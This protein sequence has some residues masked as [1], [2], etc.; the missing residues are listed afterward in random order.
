MILCYH[1]DICFSDPVFPNLSGAE[2][3]EMW[4]MLCS[5][6][7]NFEVTFAD[8]EADERT[9]KAHWEACYDFSATGRRVHN[10]IDAEFEFQDG[11]IIKHK[12][13]F[14][15]WKWSS[16]ALGPVEFILGWTPLLRKKVQRQA[17]ERLAKFMNS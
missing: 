13:T 2:V 5:Q 17:R 9:G 8:I 1:P 4:R 16:Q 3:G 6:A 10:K 7:E 12:D 14:D 11:K 15:F